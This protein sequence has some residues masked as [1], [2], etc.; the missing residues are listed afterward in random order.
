METNIVQSTVE[1]VRAAHVTQS[2]SV[3]V[4]SSPCSSTSS[5]RT[6]EA[7][8]NR[9]EEVLNNLAYWTQT[10]LNVKSGEFEPAVLA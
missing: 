4:M 1:D 8:Q 7:N 9:T 3:L 6:C 2:I 5:F 10:N